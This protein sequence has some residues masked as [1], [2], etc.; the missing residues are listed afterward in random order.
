VI[1]VVVV[2]VGFVVEIGVVVLVVGNIRR[3]GVVNVCDE[4]L[5]N[6]LEDDC[7]GDRWADTVDDNEIIDN[8]KINMIVRFEYPVGCNK[9]N[10]SRQ[11]RRLCKN[12]N[13]DSK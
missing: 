9:D 13:V 11:K 6:V 10:N 7:G 1:V 3:R 4:P 12:A 2:F 8:N 5:P